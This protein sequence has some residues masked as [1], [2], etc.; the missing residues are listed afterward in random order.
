MKQVKGWWL[1]DTDTDFDRWILDGEYQK[2][3]RDAILEFVNRD[4]NA[5]DIGAHVGFWLRDMCKQFKHVYAFEPIEEVRQ[6][7]ARNVGAENYS[8]YSVGLGAKNDVIKVNYNPAETGNTHASKDGNQTITIRKLDDMN[9]PKIDYIKVDTEGFEIE[10][11]KGGEKMI[12][13]YK[14]FIHVE[15]KGKVLVKQGLSSDD[16]DNYLKSLNYKEVFRIS[17][18]RVYAHDKKWIHH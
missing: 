2:K 18:E 7:L 8:T 9:L 6:C 15:V 3:Q 1:P 10:V 4:G 12:E 5:I 16:V 13:K 17:S 11:L 14:P